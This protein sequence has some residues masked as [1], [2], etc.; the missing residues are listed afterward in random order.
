MRLTTA[1]GAALYPVRVS[2]CVPARPRAS[3][4][5]PVRP[6][7]SPCV[8]VR[9][10]ASS[11]TMLAQLIGH[12]PFWQIYGILLVASLGFLFALSF[13]FYLPL[14]KSALREPAFTWKTQL[15]WPSDATIR[16]EIFWAVVGACF[17]V[18]NPAFAIWLQVRRPCPHTRPSRLPTSLSLSARIASP[19]SFPNPLL[20]C[21]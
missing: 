9:P 7:A 12:L 3:P 2:P 10:R 18:L 1:W 14:Y 16:R 15:R 4:R 11:D 19:A 13:L 21:P 20:T 8:P 6:S 5:V 17:A